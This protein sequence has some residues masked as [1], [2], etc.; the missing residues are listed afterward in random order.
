MRSFSFWGSVTEV[1]NPRIVL[2]SAVEL[3][4]TNWLRAMMVRDQGL[5]LVHLIWECYFGL[6]PVV[7]PVASGFLEASH[8]SLRADVCFFCE[9]YLLRSLSGSPTP[10]CDQTWSNKLWQEDFRE[11]LVG[12]PIKSCILWLWW[13]GRCW[14]PGIIS[15]NDWHILSPDPLKF[16]M[17]PWYFMGIIFQTGNLSWKPLPQPQ[18][19]QQPGVNYN[20]DVKHPLYGRS[21]SGNHGFSNAFPHPGCLPRVKRSFSRKWWRSWIPASSLLRSCC[22]MRPGA[23]PSWGEVGQVPR[24]TASPWRDPRCDVLRAHHSKSLDIS[25]QTLVNPYIYNI[26]VGGLEHF[27]FSHNN[28]PNWLSYFSEGWPN[29]QPVYQAWW[30]PASHGWWWTST[31]HAKPL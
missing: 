12:F 26:L 10:S 8:D 14:E 5:F 31:N 27:L 1:V 16:S 13:F 9:C 21:A 15:T 20:I 30:R 2:P 24:A 22:G 23:R 11:I 3:E 17:Q 7:H 28:H 29:H 6:F 19:N 18:K 25:W 4:C